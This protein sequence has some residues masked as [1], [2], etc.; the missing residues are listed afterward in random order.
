MSKT[1][2]S[3]KYY[4]PDVRQYDEALFAG[5]DYKVRVPLV[6]TE[7]A[8]REWH[9]GI[10]DPMLAKARYS[11]TKMHRFF[12]SSWYQSVHLSLTA[13]EPEAG[14][15]VTT[16]RFVARIDEG[17]ESMSVYVDSKITG[18]NTRRAEGDYVKSLQQQTKLGLAV[19]GDQDYELFI[20][21][22]VRGASGDH[23]LPLRR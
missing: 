1:P 6:K 12:K 21:Q 20:D 4:W 8:E 9:S 5:A 16:K 7:R 11:A 19:P 14:D 13:L 23:E 2:E 15:F 17:Q 3:S 22:L 10:D 18:D